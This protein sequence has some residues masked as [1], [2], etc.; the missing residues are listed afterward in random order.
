[1]MYSDAPSPPSGYIGKRL[2]YDHTA[3]D[4]GEQQRIKDAGGFITRGRYLM[5]YMYNIYVLK[6]Y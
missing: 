5:I 2:S 6:S 4:V 1:M 3:E